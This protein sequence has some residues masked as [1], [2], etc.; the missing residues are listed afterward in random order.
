MYY[1]RK[2]INQMGQNT[3]ISIL[4]IQILTAIIFLL[5]FILKKSINIKSNS[6]PQLFLPSEILF[7]FRYPHSF[8]FLLLQKSL[9]L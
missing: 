1:I 8:I 3:L 2:N 4:L 9:L 7:L 6:I 5:Y